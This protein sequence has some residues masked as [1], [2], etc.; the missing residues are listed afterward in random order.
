MSTPLPDTEIA[1]AA[2]QNF[3]DL[4]EHTVI[5]MTAIALA[6]S[7]GIP[8][9]LSPGA[10]A[11]GAG[12]FGLWQIENNHPELGAGFFSTNSST[13]GSY[14]N[15]TANGAAA[16]KIYQGQGL[17]AWSAY[18]NGSYAQFLQRAQAAAAA[19]RG[20]PQLY[21]GGFP[22]SSAFAD[23]VDK[24]LGLN[25]GAGIGPGAGAGISPNFQANNGQGY[26]D[27]LGGALTGNN[28]LFAGL[29]SLAPAFW[30]GGGAL[31]VVLAVIMLNEGSISSVAKVAAV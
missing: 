24:A 17:T 31:L 21:V 28:S 1:K 19:T 3:G 15:P 18:T 29:A 22:G 12:G 2:W 20:T 9:N 11:G 13:G 25:A 27:S 23:I 6:E 10:R 5:I 14:A 26:P 4:G 7:S 8:D 30:I 16:R